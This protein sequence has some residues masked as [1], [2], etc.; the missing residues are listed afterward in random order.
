MV[1]T[2]GRGQG[3]VL[4]K[5]TFNLNAKIYICIYTICMCISPHT[6]N[7]YYAYAVLPSSYTSTLTWPCT[8]EC[9]S[10]WPAYWP[11]AR[12][13]RNTAGAAATTEAATTSCTFLNATNEENC[14]VRCGQYSWVNAFNA[15]PSK[16]QPNAYE[17]NSVGQHKQLKGI[18]C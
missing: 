17:P 14:S 11:V 6:S 1:N 5:I 13:A 4:P 15:R 2:C 7:I 16:K 8:N 3:R 10:V 12:S 18:C 9:I